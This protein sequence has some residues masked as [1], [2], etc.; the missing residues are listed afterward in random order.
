MGRSFLQIC[1]DASKDQYAARGLDGQCRVSAEALRDLV[2]H[3]KRIDDDMRNRYYLN[4]SAP[5]LLNVLEELLEFSRI[6]AKEMTT[7]RGDY[8]DWYDKARAAIKLARGE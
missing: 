1:E 3:F 5:A 8:C 7:V 4:E 2:F 6:A